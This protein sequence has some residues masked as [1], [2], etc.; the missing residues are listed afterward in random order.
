RLSQMDL[1]LEAGI[2]TR[3]LSFVETGRSRPSPDMVVALAEQL[4]VPLRERN[5]LLLAAG[6]APRY[7]ARSLDDPAMNEVR[8]A[9]SRVLAGH[10]PY[11][12]IAVD[13]HWNLIASNEALG[14]MLE[15]VAPELLVPP[16]NTI[17]LALHPDGL[18]PRIINLG[19]YRADLLHRLDRAAR[20]TGDDMLRE[21]REEMLGY[22]GPDAPPVGAGGM[23]SAV[24]VR[25]RLASP[26]GDNGPELSFFSTITTF[27]TA[28]DVTVSE[29]AVEAFF[30]ADAQTADRQRAAAQ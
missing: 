21:L 18:A 24:T 17:R 28:V 10:E 26:P 9:V 27:G 30:P 11:P 23:E 5:E 2:S 25:L 15:G 8:E 19:E 7:G 14:P 16:V 6:Y 4:E 12:A 20:I 1:A 13:R 29:L 3:H 22:P